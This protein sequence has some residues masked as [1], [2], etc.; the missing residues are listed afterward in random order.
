MDMQR[1]SQARQDEA[2]KAIKE[3]LNCKKIKWIDN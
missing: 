2:D 1:E 3:L